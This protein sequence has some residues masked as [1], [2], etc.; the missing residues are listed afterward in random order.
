VPLL[1]HCPRG[2]LATKLDDSEKPLQLINVT[3]TFC[4]EL[5]RTGRRDGTNKIKGF[6]FPG[7]RELLDPAKDQCA[8]IPEL[9]S[10]LREH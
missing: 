5:A 1:G 3:K 2:W 4:Q 9:H 10:I 7:R 6:A 8:A